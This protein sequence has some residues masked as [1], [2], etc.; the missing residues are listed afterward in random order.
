MGK[1]DIMTKWTDQNGWDYKISSAQQKRSFALARYPE[2][3]SSLYGDNPKIDYILIATGIRV[4]N[5]SKDNINISDDKV[6]I[7]KISDYFASKDKIVRIVLF[8]MDGDAPI[9]ED[10]KLLSKYV[11]G[12]AKDF[13]TN[14][15]N[16][17]GFSKC[18][19]M[20]FNMPKY[21]EKEALSKTNLYTI[22]TPFLGTK[23]VSDRIFYPEVR[24]IIEAKISNK[25]LSKLVY[26]GIIK[27]YESI[28]S[29]S[30]MDYDIARVNG[31]SKSKLHLYD[32]SFIRNMFNSDNLSSIKKVN[33]YTNL[34]TSIDDKTFDQAVKEKNYAGIVLCIMDELFYD[35]K[36]D[37]IVL[38]DD[39]K[40]VD[41]KLE[42][43]K[44]IVLPSSHHDVL[45]INQ[46]LLAI[47]GLVDN[48]INDMNEE[49]KS[50]QKIITR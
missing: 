3:N 29:N 39:Q 13:Q 31:I 44:S 42:N 20:A 6:Y 11:N 8:L 24:K 4:E 32:S 23:I 9:I 16:I 46:H 25:L 27:K 26:E 48:N 28:I 40:Q 21:F 35:Q 36:S 47:L 49:H 45:S 14:S 41:D 34:V 10:S 37:G 2:I 22:A 5:V 15:I 43:F 30:H 1:I 18:G 7:D 38:T 50:K 17:I 33:K 12:I 19:A